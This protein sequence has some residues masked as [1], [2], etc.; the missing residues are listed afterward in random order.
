MA[1]TAGPWEARVATK[2]FVLI[3]GVKWLKFKHNFCFCEGNRFSKLN[4]YRQ[5]VI[6]EEQLEVLGVNVI[7]EVSTSG[8]TTWLKHVVLR[9]INLNCLGGLH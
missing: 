4:N 1:V 8:H 3:F 2:V 9:R 5:V 7:E 6:G